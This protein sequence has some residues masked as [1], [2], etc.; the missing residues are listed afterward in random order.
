MFK[1]IILLPIFLMLLFSCSVVFAEISVGDLTLA[2][3]VKTETSLRVEGLNNDLTKF[4]NIFQLSGEYPVNDYV[5]LLAR[6]DTGMMRHMIF[7]TN[8]ILLR[9]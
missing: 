9:M 3:Y 6:Y 7:V 2:G 4:K 5:T 8:M 1:R